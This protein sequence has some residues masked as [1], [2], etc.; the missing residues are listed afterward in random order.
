L[1]ILLKELKTETVILEGDTRAFLGKAVE[2]MDIAKSAGA[3]SFSI[4]AEE[5][6]IKKDVK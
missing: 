3:K 4:A 6:P 1:P 2:I 5:N